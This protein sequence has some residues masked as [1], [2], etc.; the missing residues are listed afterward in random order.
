MEAA[1]RFADDLRLFG[2]AVS[3]GGFESLVLPI[4][5]ENTLA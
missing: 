5:P 3:W 4:N 1:I 2:I